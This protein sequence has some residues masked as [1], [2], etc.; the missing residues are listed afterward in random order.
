MAKAKAPLINAILDNEA[1]NEHLEKQQLELE[2]EK[3]ARKDRIKAKRTVNSKTAFNQLPAEEKQRYSELVAIVPDGHG[4]T[5]YQRIDAIFAYFVT[6]YIREA[7]RLC[8]I[9]E[10][11]M[12]SWA[13]SS[14]WKSAIQKVKEIKQDELDVQYT[15]IIDRTVTAI[16]DRLEHGEE[17]ISKGGT[18]VR[19]GVGAKDLML[20]NAM[21]FDKRALVRRDPTEITQKTITVEDRNNIL[22]EQ[23]K[24]IAR[25]QPILEGE[26][27][28]NHESCD[29]G[30]SK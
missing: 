27:I 5:A 28:D 21:A 4:Y 1:H 18:K 17:K 7:A 2:A 23:F 24:K 15:S 16:V 9:S 30:T 29:I 10:G 19:V 13:Q 22:A 26:I 14:W 11:T 12:L 20:I 8:G 6:G 3:Q 25:A